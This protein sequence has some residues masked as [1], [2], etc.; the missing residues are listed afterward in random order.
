VS[1]EP[2]ESETTKSMGGEDGGTADI[3]QSQQEVFEM[4]REWFDPGSKHNGGS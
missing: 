4:A 3:I 2:S 1:E